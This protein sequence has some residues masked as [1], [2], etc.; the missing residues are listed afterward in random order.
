MTADL[1]PLWPD[2][3][4]QP[5]QELSIDRF[6]HIVRNVTQPSLTPFLPDPATATGAAVIV[7]PGGGFQLLPIENEGTLVAQW[8]VDHGI[9]A[10]VLRYQL[11]PTD[12]HDNVFLMQL[13]QI[14]RDPQTA[15]LGMRPQLKAAIVD[16][17]QAVQMVRARAA[18]WGIDP[19]RIGVVGFSGGGVVT[20]GIIAQDQ[21][22]SRLNFAALI[23]TPVWEEVVTPRPPAELL[24]LFLTLANDDPFISDGNLPLYNTWHEAGYPV[25]LHIYAKGGHAFGMKQ[26]GLPTDHWIERFADWL[27]VQ[28]LLA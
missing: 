3:P 12:V 1:I 18:E 23:Y 6:G 16:G 26:Q 9:A 19:A 13:S 21:A 22:K 15:M 4:P 25:E 14:A 24:P 10:F 28:G 11:A 8:L 5:D 20:S 2:V 17:Q 7:V 27:Q